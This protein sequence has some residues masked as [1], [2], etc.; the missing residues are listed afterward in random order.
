MG[1]S[2]ISS[3]ERPNNNEFFSS[4]YTKNIDHKDNSSYKGI[5]TT[6]ESENETFGSSMRTMPDSKRESKTLVEYSFYWK[7]GGNDV[8]ITGSFSN[9]KSW[10]KLEKIGE[11][12]FHIKLLLPKDKHYFKFIID[13]EWKHSSYYNSEVDEKGN[14]NN[15]VDLSTLSSCSTKK[16]VV[17]QEIKKVNVKASQ[18]LF[19]DSY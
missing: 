14:T 5:K 12:L 4:Y 11:N 16:V 8:Y 7:D 18:L 1:Q 6:T 10:F 9:W 15:I 3:S 13:K 17:Q 19:N 2:Q